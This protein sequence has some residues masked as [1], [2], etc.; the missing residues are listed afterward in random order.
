MP[1]K[2]K[3]KFVYFTY[4]RNKPLLKCLK[5]WAYIFIF[6]KFDDYYH[7]SPF[8]NAWGA[9]VLTLTLLTYFGGWWVFYAFSL[10]PT[11]I[12]LLIILSLKVFHKLISI[13]IYWYI[14]IEYIHTCEWY[15]FCKIVNLLKENSM[16][17]LN[18]MSL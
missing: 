12:C 16:C 6:G 13:H 15:I 8:P 18:I 11:R 3:M 9:T 2:F 7:C 1:Q 4:V 17:R 14:W 10:A 5:R